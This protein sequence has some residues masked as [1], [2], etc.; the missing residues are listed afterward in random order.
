MLFDE[1]KLDQTPYFEAVE[2][3]KRKLRDGDVVVGAGGDGT[4]QVTLQGAFQSE[5]N[6]QIGF[7]PLGNANDFAG[8]LNGRA[9]NPEEIF[10]S[11]T[12]EFHPLVLSVNGVEKFFVAAYATFG[13]TMVA[14]K[15]LNSEKARA[16]RERHPNLPPIAALDADSIKGMSRDI[17][18]LNFPAFSRDGQ[19]YHAD[20][21]GFF[22]TAAAHGL[23]RP[24][25]ADN[26]LTRDDFFFH[27]ANVRDQLLG[28]TIFGKSLR[29]GGW[30]TFGLP[31]GISD[32]EELRFLQPTDLIC[33]IGGDN[34]PLQ[35]VQQISA[36]RSTRAIKIF[37]PRAEKIQQK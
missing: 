35:N 6:V 30:A 28:K 13:A 25:G 27:S 33:Q 12:I 2:E 31:G 11:P 18:A 32:A 3:V 15:W 16:E 36:T 24:T 1:I 29:A 4:N 23:L 7:L 20:S 8:A 19:I 5:K 37:A 10:A 26:F 9:T 21:V 22:I 34:V 17:N 14:V